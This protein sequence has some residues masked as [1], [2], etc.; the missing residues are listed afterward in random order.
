MHLNVALCKWLFSFVF[1]FTSKAENL[2]L[3][4]DVRRVLYDVVSKI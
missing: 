1:F 2:Y 3:Y 4:L